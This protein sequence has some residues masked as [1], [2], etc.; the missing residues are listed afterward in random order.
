[1]YNIQLQYKNEPVVKNTLKSD[2]GV[3]QYLLLNL[4]GTVSN[5][6]VN[7]FEKTGSLHTTKGNYSI[8]VKRNDIYE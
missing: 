2:W 8:T 6:L 3:R 5:T 4:P 1:M 7:E